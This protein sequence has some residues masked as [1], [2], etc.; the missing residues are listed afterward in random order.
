MSQFYV[1]V[2]VNLAN[3]RWN[4]DWNAYSIR[5]ILKLAAGVMKRDSITFDQLPYHLAVVEC[6]LKRKHFDNFGIVSPREVSTAYYALV[7]TLDL[8]L[9]EGVTSGIEKNPL[10]FMN[11]WKEGKVTWGGVYAT[12]EHPNFLGSTAVEED[13]WWGAHRM[14][15]YR[16]QEGEIPQSAL[17]EASELEEA[18]FANLYVQSQTFYSWDFLSSRAVSALTNAGVRRESDRHVSIVIPNSVA[19]AD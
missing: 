17:D 8:F 19:L 6:T 7:N 15:E 10:K 1:P 9:R 2:H 4:K 3:A 11:L 13:F 16:F 5:S 14:V 12:P 18:A